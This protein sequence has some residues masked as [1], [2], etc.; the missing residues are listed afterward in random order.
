MTFMKFSTVVAVTAVLGLGACTDPAMLSNSGGPSKEQ[1]G[2]IAG[3][4]LGAGIGALS[5]SSNKTG[6]V[7]GGAAVGAIAGGLIGSQLDKQEAEL[8]QSISNDGISIV[9]TGDRLIVLL[10]NDLTFATDSSAITP[11]VRSDLLKVAD[12]LVRY[13][14]S[15]V[16]VIGHTDSDGDAAYNQ[17]LSERRANVVADQIQAGGVPY[18]RIRTI[19]RGEEEPVASNLTEE[20]KA[21]N[22]RVE[23]VIIPQG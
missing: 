20:G 13:P 14:N 6:A 7:L 4:I 9:N 23:I 16:Q 8:R 2:L 5:N 15:M 11:S 1:Q 18:N 17:G 3:G 12:S 10:P 19:G 21:R 22:R